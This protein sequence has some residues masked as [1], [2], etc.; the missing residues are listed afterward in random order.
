[1][2]GIWKTINDWKSKKPSCF[3]NLD[4]ER[5]SLVNMG[6]ELWKLS[7]LNFG[8]QCHDEPDLV[9]YWSVLINCAYPYLCIILIKNSIMQARQYFYNKTK[10][11]TYY[12]SFTYSILTHKYI[13]LFFFYFFFFLNFFFIFFFCK[14]FLLVYGKLW[15]VVVL[16]C[17]QSPH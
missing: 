5:L 3:K 13:A 14:M 7:Y 6:T 17:L 15:N 1:M 12:L 16:I 9:C 2:H 4:V 10:R 11:H 8:F